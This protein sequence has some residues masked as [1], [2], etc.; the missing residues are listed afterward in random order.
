MQPLLRVPSAGPCCSGTSS[1][2]LTVVSGAAGVGARVLP[3]GHRARPAVRTLCTRG[4]PARGWCPQRTCDSCTWPV[5]SGDSPAPMKHTQ[6]QAASVLG[7]AFVF[8]RIRTCFA[9]LWVCSGRA[10]HICGFWNCD[11]SGSCRRSA[12]NRNSL[13]GGRASPLSVCSGWRA[14]DEALCKVHVWRRI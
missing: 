9:K 3:A 10:T 11:E 2:A 4:G 14:L 6:K 13:S 5:F 12:L 8:A 1:V 7:S